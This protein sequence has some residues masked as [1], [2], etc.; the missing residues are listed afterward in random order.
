MEITSSKKNV[1]KGLAVLLALSAVLS[2]FSSG[3]ESVVN[4]PL[5]QPVVAYADQ[6][7]FDISIIESGV[8]EARR[9]VTLASQLP[10]N[11][12]KIIFLRPEGTTVKPGD[13]IVKFDKSPFIDN[14]AKLTGEVSDASAA[15][16]QA[17]EELQLIMQQG[18]ADTESMQH[19]LEVARLKHKNLVEAELPL[20][21]AQSKKELQ[22]AEQKYSLAKEKV[23]SMKAL[24]KQ[25]FTK[26]REYEQ[27]QAD[28]SSSRAEMALAKQQDSLLRELIAPGE[29]RQSELKLAELERKVSEQEKGTRQ[30]RARKNA[31]LIR[32]NHRY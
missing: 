9:S 1:I 24:L 18:K 6:G 3:K 27:A 2:V 32:L 21:K 23:D 25:G 14:V 16:A 11:Q 10:S 7:S 29:I 31:A 30:K 12:A 28:I 15:L 8:L 26:R 20:R 22:T 4:T 5:Q 13:V 17:E 19:N